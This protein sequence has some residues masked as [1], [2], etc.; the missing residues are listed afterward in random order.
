VKVEK[1]EDL[2][3]KLADREEPVTWNNLS[4][5]EQKTLLDV[6]WD[7]TAYDRS[8]YVLPSGKD[9][10]GTVEDPLVWLVGIF[11]AGRLTPKVI[12]LVYQ[13]AGPAYV[14]GSQ[15]SGVSLWPSPWDGRQI[16]NGITYTYHALE[17]MMPPGFGGRGV[18]PSVVQNALNFGVQSPGSQPNTVRYTY[19]N[20][21]VV[22]N[23]VQNW[24]VTVWK[25]GH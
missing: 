10:A 20:V 4:K 12:H 22:W 18:P 17:S 16:I 8:D 1:A 14:Y 24:V 5:K 6:G 9:I 21:V 3:N 25:T 11:G 19:E 15:N 13:L 2:L 7:P 23:Y